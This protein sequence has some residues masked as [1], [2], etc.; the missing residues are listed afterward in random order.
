[1]IRKGEIKQLLYIDYSNNLQTIIIQK[2]T[3]KKKEVNLVR[4]LDK[5][6]MQ[7]SPLFLYVSNKDLKMKNLNIPSVIASEISNIQGCN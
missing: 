6:S 2:L 3:K 5:R 1:M 7:K 4:T